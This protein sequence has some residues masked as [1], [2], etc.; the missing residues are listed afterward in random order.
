L[1]LALWEAAG[2]RSQFAMVDVR[3]LGPEISDP[4]TNDEALSY[5][6]VAVMDPDAEKVGRRFSGAAVELALSSYPGFF[7]TTPPGE[8]TAYAVFWPATIPAHLVPMRVVM[9]DR[10]WEVSSVPPGAKSQASSLKSQASDSERHAMD[11]AS[12]TRVPLGSIAGARSGDKGGNANVGFWVRTSEQYRW[13]E[14]YLTTDR[15][16]TLMPEANGLEI[17][18]YELPNLLALNFVLRGLL[19]DG[20]SSSTRTDPQAKSLG[21][22]LRARWVDVPRVL[23]GGGQ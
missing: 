16:H 12:L 17:D 8:A 4:A 23:I 13:M 20:V 21:E 1:E 22:F 3:L 9:D 14:Q 11:P 19:G 10:E 5:L 2:G 15:L 18:R 7:L 6:R